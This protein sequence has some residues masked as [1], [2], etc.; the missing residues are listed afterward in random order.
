MRQ[1]KF[2]PL[3]IAWL[4]LQLTHRTESPTTKTIAIPTQNFNPVIQFLKL[5]TH[6]LSLV[7]IFN[8][9]K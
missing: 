7:L 2:I 3:I 4:L 5:I 6:K 1:R 8:L 9:D